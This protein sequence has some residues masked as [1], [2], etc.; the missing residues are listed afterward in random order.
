MTVQPKNFFFSVKN[1]SEVIVIVGEI[2][3]SLRYLFVWILV[4]GLW[5]VIHIKNA[6]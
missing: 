1:S 2:N 6:P 3:E 4:Q 5:K